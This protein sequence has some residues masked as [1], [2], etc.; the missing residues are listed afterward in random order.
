MRALL[1]AVAIG[2]LVT[3]SADAT[4]TAASCAVQKARHVS[5]R[6]ATAKDVMEVSI[7]AGPCDRATL[8]IV[9]RSDA[10]RVL[11]SYANPFEQHVVRT[12]DEPLAKEAERFVDDLLARGVE[13][14]GVLPPWL[15]PDDY[16]QKHAGAIHVTR[17]AYESLRANPRPML[18]HATYFEGWISVVYDE[19]QRKTVTV[20]SGGT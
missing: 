14:S 5:F 20:V 3:A 19:T 8:T 18:S 2:S 15:P 17:E 12:K 4:N 1:L 16:E 6:S 7:G 13:S 9:V 10:G 11:Y